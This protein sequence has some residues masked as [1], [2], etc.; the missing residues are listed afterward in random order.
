MVTL[1]YLEETDFDSSIATDED[2]QEVRDTWDDDVHNQKRGFPVAATFFHVALWLNLDTVLTVDLAWLVRLWGHRGDLKTVRGADQRLQA[3]KETEEAAMAD[4]G[5][6]ICRNWY[7]TAMSNRRNS[8]AQA[9][10]SCAAAT[11]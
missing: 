10:V 8:V 2:I 5:A 9:R 3:H 7:G 1:I 11:K 6:T 4:I